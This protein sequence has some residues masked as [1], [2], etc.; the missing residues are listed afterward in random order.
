MPPTTFETTEALRQ[1]RTNAR[2]TVGF[3]P[4]MGA[5]HEGHASLIRRARHENDHVAVSIFVNPSQFGPNED[6]ARYPRTLAQDLDLCE[7]AGAEAVFMPTPEIIYPKGYSTWVDVEGISGELCGA[8]RPGHF[9]GVA[10]VVL[11]LLQ[12]V[13]PTRAYFGRKDAQ[14]ALLLIRMAQD[15][16]LNTRIVTCPTVREPDGL[17]LSSRN[18]YLSAEERPRALAL[19]RAL[20]AAQTA[21]RSGERDRAKLETILRQGLSPVD[22]IDYARVLRM[23]DLKQTE[24]VDE[25]ALCAVAAFVGATRLIDN[26]VLAETEDDGWPS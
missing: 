12:L 16:N 21:W 9:R 1:W 6:L 7:A 11:K 8:S 17:A 2:G 24:T 26:T 19:S 10:T 13:Q 5:L 15:L 25:P 22:R 20:Q 14:Q 18:R 4:T 23:R 3:V